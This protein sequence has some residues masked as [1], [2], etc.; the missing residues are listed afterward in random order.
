MKR[1]IA[2]ALLGGFCAV[3]FLVNSDIS[4][5]MFAEIIEVCFK[6]IVPSVFPFVVA[7]GML[8]SAIESVPINIRITLIYLLG[9]IFGPPINVSMASELC[10]NQEIGVNTYKKLVCCGGVPSI[11]FTLGMCG[12]HFGY[13]KAFCLYLITVLSAIICGGFF[14]GD[15]ICSKR[16]DDKSKRNLLCLSVIS[17][18][19]RNGIQKT[20]NVCGFVSFFYVLSGIICYG[21]NNRYVEVIICGF[22]EFS[23]GCMRA[24]RLSDGFQLVLCA[25]ILSFS[26]MSVFLQCITTEREKGCEFVISDYLIS[27]TIQGILSALTA[28]LFT[29]KGVRSTVIFL[30]ACI[31]IAIIFRV[32]QT[33][34]KNKLIT[35]CKRSIIKHKN[36]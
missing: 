26:G 16:Y 23:C 32:L 10:K 14:F 1:K 21:I 18:S 7:S 30:S 33:V 29:Y 11:A 20:L 25:G 28:Y 27:R 9:L 31:S 5:R 24:L 15:D 4:K 2:V 34:N 3:L 8:L 19:V 36:P 6:N 13:G 17:D 22:F 35:V 12:K